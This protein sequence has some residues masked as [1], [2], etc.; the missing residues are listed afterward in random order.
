MKQ[1]KSVHTY[2]IPKKNV[3]LVYINIKCV[4]IFTK[5]IYNNVTR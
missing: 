3:K 4:H 1:Q 5:L 2:N